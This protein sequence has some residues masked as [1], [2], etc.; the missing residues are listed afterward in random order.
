MFVVWKLI[1]NNWLFI[2][3]V[4]FL[5]S[6]STFNFVWIYID[7]LNENKPDNE[8]ERKIIVT[9]HKE[10]VLYASSSLNLLEGIELFNYYP[11]RKTLNIENIG[12]VSF[13]K[14][15]NIYSSLIKGRFLE[16]RYNEVVLPKYINNENGF[17]D[18]SSLL[19]ESVFIKYVDDNGKNKKMEFDVVGIYDNEEDDT[20]NKICIYGRDLWKLEQLDYYN[21]ILLVNKSIDI[22]QMQQI[23]ELNDFS[24]KFCV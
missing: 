10:N 11:S 6:A 18:S 17:I 20:E 12:E 9:V 24:T 8:D 19:G 7:H 2:L 1:K 22:E 21:F 4:V 13:D 5:V 23:L 15:L 14:E 16:F 3:T